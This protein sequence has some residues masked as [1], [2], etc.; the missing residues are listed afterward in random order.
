MLFPTTVRGL[1]GQFPHDA[2]PP[3][4]YQCASPPPVQF[5]TSSSLRVIS[6]ARAG[7]GG[8]RGGAG[9]RKSLRG[10]GGGGRGSVG[11]IQVLKENEA[12]HD[13]E[14]EG[15]NRGIRDNGDGGEWEEKNN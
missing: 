9:R 15:D 6:A 4:F 13:G 3:A 1:L 11:E 14:G 2:D 12:R 7:G 8:A 10:S 5:P